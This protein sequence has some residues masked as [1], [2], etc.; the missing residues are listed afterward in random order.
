MSNKVLDTAHLLEKSIRDSEEF[1][2]LKE[3]YKELYKDAE[4]KKLFEEFRDLQ[5]K[6]QEKQMTNEPL[7]QEEIIRV[8]EMVQ[9]VQQNAKISSLMEAEQRMSNVIMEI[10]KIVMKPLEDLYNEQFSQ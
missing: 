8:Q 9:V 5:L 10:N 2:Q 6:L 7:L 4:A 3:Q 1:A